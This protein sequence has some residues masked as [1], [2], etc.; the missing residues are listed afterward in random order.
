MHTGE[1]RDFIAHN[2]HNIQVIYNPTLLNKQNKTN[3]KQENMNQLKQKKKS[4]Q[5]DPKKT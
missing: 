3:K 4:K 5:T 1:F 2:S